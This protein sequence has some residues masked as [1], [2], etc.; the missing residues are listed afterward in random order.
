MREYSLQDPEY[1]KTVDLRNYK[2]IIEDSIHQ[3]APDAIVTVYKDRY[4]ITPDLSKGQLIKIGRLIAQTTLGQ[5]CMI[6]PILFKGEVI[7]D[8]EVYLESCPSNVIY[9]YGSNGLQ[10]MN[11]RNGIISDVSP[12]SVSHYIS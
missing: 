8:D 12:S 6:R 1:R 7:E 4:T 9:N 3:V 11:I 5:Y 10:R 2:T